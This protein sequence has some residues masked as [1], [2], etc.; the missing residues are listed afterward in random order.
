MEN[1]RKPKPETRLD[2][3]RVELVRPTHQPSK[4]ELEESIS[5]PPMLLEETARRL[6]EPVEIHHI[7]KPQPEC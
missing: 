7:H 3:R 5:L 1:S 6:M 2:P 4:A